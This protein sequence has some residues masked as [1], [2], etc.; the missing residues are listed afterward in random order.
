MEKCWY[1]GTKVCSLY[2]PRVRLERELERCEKIT[3][4]EILPANI[5][6]PPDRTVDGGD[7]FSFYLGIRTHSTLTNNA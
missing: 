4:L 2:C 6:E 3:T 7:H 5:R 1:C